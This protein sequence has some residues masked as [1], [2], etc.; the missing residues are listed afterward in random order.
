MNAKGLAPTLG[1]Q[2]VLMR[3]CLDQGRFGASSQSARQSGNI[4]KAIE[5]AVDI[6]TTYV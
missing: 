1:I 4:G 6:E 2:L 5:I 3:E